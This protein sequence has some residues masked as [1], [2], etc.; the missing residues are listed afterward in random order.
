MK[1]YV[2]RQGVELAQIAVSDEV[3]VKEFASELTGESGFEVWL[4]DADEPLPAK[5]K[6]EKSGIKERGHVQVSRCKRVEVT[7][8]YGGESRTKQFSPAATIAK[9]FDWACGPK[10]FH[11]TGSEKAKHT[12]GIC[13]T[14]QQPH[15]SEHIGTFATSNCDL[16][17]DLL[18]K[19]RFEG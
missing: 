15:R 12:L 9:V 14:G 1:I 7:V 8:R 4:E 6:L 11:L 13:G 18:P 16:C 10:A 19:E 2:H 17:L 3:T 5:T